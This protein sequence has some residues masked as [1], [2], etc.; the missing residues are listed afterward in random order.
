[1]V[2]RIPDEGQGHVPEGSPIQYKHYPPSSGSHY[3]RWARYE[4]Y[5]EELPE[6]YWVHNLEH[7]AIVVLY[8]CRSVACPEVES[9]LKGLYSELKPSK[10]GSVKLVV[11]PY[12]RSTAQV[13]VLAWGYQM[14]LSGPDVN[15]I[16]F[17]YNAHVD[18]GPEDAP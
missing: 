9:T 6:G 15:S 2:Q 1:V 8:N 10:W 16:R 4:A 7:G 11:T 5:A 13:T 12:T 18:Q 3:P 14:D 17:F